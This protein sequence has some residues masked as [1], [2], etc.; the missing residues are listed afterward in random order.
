MAEG[1]GGEQKLM[2][3]I[4]AKAKMLNEKMWNKLFVKVLKLSR[5]GGN[6]YP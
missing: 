3:R 2:N 4:R 1:H 5:G 6:E